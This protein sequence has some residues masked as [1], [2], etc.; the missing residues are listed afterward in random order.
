MDEME[1]FAGGIVE[2]QPK[3]DSGGVLGA[4][5]SLIEPSSAE[6]SPIGKMVAKK[7]IGPISSTAKRLIGHEISGMEISNVIKGRDPWRYIQFKG[8]EQVMPVTKDVLNDLARQFGEEAYTTAAS[9]GSKKQ[10]LQMAIKSAEMRLRMKGSTPYTRSEA[11]ELEAQHLNNLKELELTP[12]TK[13][14]IKYR[15]E[16]INIPK[17]YADLLT[18][19]GLAKS[20]K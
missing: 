17:V 18:S 7:V 14:A 16:S 8:T 2:Q 13:V 11:A 19:S 3:Q 5:S 6:A 9:A 1:Q 20:I 10:A 15:G 4:L 12:G